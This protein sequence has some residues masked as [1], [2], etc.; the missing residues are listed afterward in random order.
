MFKTKIPFS[1][2]RNC[3]LYTYEPTFKLN[4]YNIAS[5]IHIKAK[6]SFRNPVE[7]IQDVYIPMF[8][9]LLFFF[10]MYLVQVIRTSLDH[11]AHLLTRN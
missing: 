8:F 4:S 2:P 10:T 7:R 5:P 6:E 9:F 1:S 3:L 11:V